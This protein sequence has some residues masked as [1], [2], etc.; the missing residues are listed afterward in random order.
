MTPEEIEK[1]YYDMLQSYYAAAYYN[2]RAVVRGSELLKHCGK[3]IT[4]SQKTLSSV[5]LNSDNS[6]LRK[7]HDYQEE[8]FVDPVVDLNN[9]V[10]GIDQNDKEAVFLAEAFVKNIDFR[11][12]CLKD[13][14]AAM[15]KL[16]GKKGAAANADVKSK[17]YI[18]SAVQYSILKEALATQEKENL[19]Q[20]AKAVKKRFKVEV[21]DNEVKTAKWSVKIE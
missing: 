2:N 18:N 16:S 19:Y 3:E 20:F 10:K 17:G 6:D 14:N 12:A 11:N 21:K 9:F 4:I 7:V 1:T 15:S 8:Y 5:T 13:G